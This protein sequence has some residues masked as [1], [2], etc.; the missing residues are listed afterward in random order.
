MA[1][2]SVNH[3]ASLIAGVLLSLLCAG[4]VYYGLSSTAVEVTKDDLGLPPLEISTPKLVAERK[5]GE[6]EKRSTT[7]ET[8]LVQSIYRLHQLQFGDPNPD[9]VE[10]A[11]FELMHNV[12]ELAL[13]YG[14]YR[15]ILHAVDPV[16]HGCQNALEEVQSGLK[17]GSMSVEALKTAEAPGL[18]EYKKT[19]GSVYPILLQLKLVDEKGIWS[20]PNAPII[21]SILNRLRMAA[22]SEDRIPATELLTPYEMEILYLWRFHSPAF[23]SEDKMQFAQMAERDLPG[24]LAEEWIAQV[25]YESGDMARARDFYQEACKKRKGDK[26]LERKCRL[27]DTL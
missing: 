25:A 15:H 14:S 12:N 9:T 27:A 13:A 1:H 22:L 7:H 16:I 21:F 5:A 8:A 18:D 20:D 24:T 6:P 23:S 19:C 26:I 17:S 10:E 4:G 11:A 3:Q 2:K